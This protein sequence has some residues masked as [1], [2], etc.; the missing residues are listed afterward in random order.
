MKF[1]KTSLARLA[2]CD[3]RIQEIMKIAI[4]RTKVDFGIAEGHRSLADQQKYFAEGKSEKDGIIKISKHQADPSLAVDVYGY[5]NGKSCYSVAVLCYLAGLLNAIAVEL[6]YDLHWGGN[7]DDDGE[8]ITDQ[9][10]V[11]LP[12]HEIK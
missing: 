1:S 9:N 12:H 2:T 3:P 4:V 5:V 10:F 11:D 8:I 7:F 6:G